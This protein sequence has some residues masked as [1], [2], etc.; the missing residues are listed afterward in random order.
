MKT[1]PLLS[2][3]EYSEIFVTLLLC[4]TF[5]SS[6]II[7]HSSS[8]WPWLS[9]FVVWFN[10][11]LKFSAL[12]CWVHIPYIEECFF[13]VTSNVS[14]SSESIIGLTVWLFLS[15]CI[16]LS[17]SLWVSA[18]VVRNSSEEVYLFSTIS[19]NKVVNFM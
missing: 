10:S 1:R 15:T 11:S 6:S 4:S 19:K 8:V 2:A 18:Y 7:F 13:A 17:V 16:D 9:L 14:G 5:L 3:F 12:Y